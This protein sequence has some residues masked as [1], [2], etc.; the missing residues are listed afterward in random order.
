MLYAIC[1]TLLL[2]FNHLHI[3]THTLN[4][5]SHRIRPQDSLQPRPRCSHPCHVRRRDR[6]QV[7]CQYHFVIIIIIIIIV[8]VVVV[9]VVTVIIII[10][11]ILLL[12]IILL[13][14]SY[15]LM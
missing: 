6:L 3:D 4:L 11:I 8:V 15:N 1:H 2:Y 10:I 12:L 13:S 14:I 9:V 5:H 7:I